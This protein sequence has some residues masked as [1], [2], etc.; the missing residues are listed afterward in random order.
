MMYIAFYILFILGLVLTWIFL[1]PAFET[2]GE[3]ILDIWNDL[4]DRIKNNK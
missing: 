1:Y 4:M 2:L 3:I